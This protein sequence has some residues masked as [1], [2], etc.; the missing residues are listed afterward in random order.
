MNVWSRLWFTPTRDQGLGTDYGKKGA[1]SSPPSSE[2]M[3]YDDIGDVPIH[4]IHHSTL[5]KL[6]HMA[7]KCDE[8]FPKGMG[9]F[10]SFI[11][12][13]NYFLKLTN[14]LVGRVHSVLWA[15]EELTEWSMRGRLSWES[16]GQIVHY[17][18]CGVQVNGLVLEEKDKKIIQFRNKIIKWT[19]LYRQSHGIQMSSHKLRHE[20]ND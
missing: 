10:I 14:G 11:Y 20:G 17:R 18:L 1:T 4:H 5:R 19:L 8:R 13:L 15:H 7:V 2:M 6:W 9:Q 3:I 12:E 16:E